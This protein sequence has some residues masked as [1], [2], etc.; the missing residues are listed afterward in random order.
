MH[1]AG[2]DMGIIELTLIVLAITLLV[3][4]SKV[5]GGKR[6]FVEM[7]YKISKLDGQ[8]PSLVHSVWYAW[9]TCPMC[10]GAWVAVPLCYFEAVGYAWY[11]AALMVFGLNWLI[12]C[13]ENT[14]FQFGYFLEKLSSKEFIEV[15]KKFLEAN[16]KAV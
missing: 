1:V 15:L 11:W 14:L 2:D 16:R 8:K 12:H 3:T 6:E 7:R 4:K 9:W 13:A 5:V 10:L